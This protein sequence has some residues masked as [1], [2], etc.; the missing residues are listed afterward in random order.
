MRKIRYES[1]DSPNTDNHLSVDTQ[2]ELVIDHPESNQRS[3]ALSEGFAASSGIRPETAE[4]GG[5]LKHPETKDGVRSLSSV[6]KE[7]A[8][9]ADN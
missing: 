6:D 9:L 4:S 7:N 2:M 5:T 1:E 8:G 3:R